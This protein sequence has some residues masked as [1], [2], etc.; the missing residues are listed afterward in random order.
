MLEIDNSRYQSI[1][2]LFQIVCLD[3]MFMLAA[4]ICNPIENKIQDILPLVGVLIFLVI[5]YTPFQE[6]SYLLL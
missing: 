1:V 6:M 5:L 3:E 2:R 4:L